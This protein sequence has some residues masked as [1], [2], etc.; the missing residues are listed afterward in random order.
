MTTPPAVSE[1]TSPATMP[2]PPSRPARIF[3]ITI[4]A[5]LVASAVGYGCLSLVTL[6]ARQHGTLDRR[7]TG[8]IRAVS[9]QSSPAAIAVNGTGAPGVV[10]VHSAMSWSWGR[11][12]LTAVLQRDGTLRVSLVCNNWQ[13]IG[14]QGKLQLVV[15]AGV[16]VTGS[17]SGGGIRVTGVHGPIQVSSAGGG[18]N[19]D[20]TDGDLDLDSSGGGVHATR[21]RSERVVASSSG[22]GVTVSFAAEPRDVHVTSSGGGVHVVVPPGSGPYAVD[23]SASGG[24]THTGVS[25]DPQSHLR[26]YAHS[27]GG[28]VTVGYE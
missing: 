5:V 2:T 26:I 9:V 8:T 20:D 22:G 13:P 10:T 23:D 25:T 27:S 3:A 19:V 4:G 12:H 18:V 15:P 14:C 16:A 11:P 28:G 6:L 21:V 17:S 24:G 7:V 1:P